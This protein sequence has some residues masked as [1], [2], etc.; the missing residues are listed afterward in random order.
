M[1][2]KWDLVKDAM[3]TERMADYIRK[4]FPMLDHVPIAFITAKKGKNVLR[5]LQLAIQLH[6]QAG[7][8][9]THRG[10]EP[11][12]PRRGRGEPAADDRAAASRKS[13]TPRRSAFNR[14]QSYFSPTVRSCSTTLTCDT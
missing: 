2:N 14:R 5:L 10:P 3:A 11:R 6:K 7:T 4:I 8:R 9:V 1:V 13:S 12:G